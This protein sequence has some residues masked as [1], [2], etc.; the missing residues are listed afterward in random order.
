MNRI[1][2]NVIIEKTGTVFSTLFDASATAGSAYPL[3]LPDNR[4]WDISGVVGVTGDCFGMM[5]IRLNLDL[6]SALMERSRIHPPGDPQ[7]QQ[8]MS[9]MIGEI[10]NVISV[11]VLSELV[12]DDF[13]LSIPVIIQGN[14]HEISWP[15]KTAVTAFPFETLSFGMEI[16]VGLSC[17]RFKERE[18]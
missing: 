2:E 8:L 7:G 10:I 11:N 15:K 12:A 18:A 16:Q 9:D 6:A 4:H 13:R 1:I 17:D 14:R 5:A 3:E